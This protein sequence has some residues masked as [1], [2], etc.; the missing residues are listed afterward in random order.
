MTIR[1]VMGNVLMDDFCWYWSFSVL[2]K[3]LAFG[4]G[5]DFVYVFDFAA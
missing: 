2:G 5:L 1:M 3:S 4:L